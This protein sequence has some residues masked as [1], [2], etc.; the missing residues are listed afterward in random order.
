[1]TKIY[2]PRRNPP[3]SFAM[4]RSQAII[5]P[6]PVWQSVLL[7]IWNMAWLL[8]VVSVLIILFLVK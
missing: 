4:K 6:L 2:D 5:R 3:P 8:L 7:F 1:M